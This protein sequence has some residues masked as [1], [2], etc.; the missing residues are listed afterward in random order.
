MQ[1]PTSDDAGPADAPVAVIPQRADPTTTGIS[2][3]DA[4]LCLRVAS[5]LDSLAFL[6][7][8]SCDVTGNGEVGAADVDM[9]LGRR[10][11]LESEF[12][13]EALC[14]SAWIFAPQSASGPAGFSLTPPRI[15]AGSCLTGRVTFE[16]PAAQ[17][18]YDTDWTGL[19]FGDSSGDHGP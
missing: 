3:L 9:I 6:P 1:Y 16:A 2:A 7:T 14:G 10:V 8:M 18:N 5:G 17:G 15:D 11:G 13:V 4:A 12:P 19:R